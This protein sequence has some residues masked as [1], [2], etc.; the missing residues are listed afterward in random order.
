ME[1]RDGNWTLYDHDL[2]TGRT[3]WHYFDGER[4]HFRTDYPVDQILQDNKAARNDLAGQN[5]GGGQRIASIP[6]NIYFEQLDEAHAQGDEKYMSKWLNDIEH[7][8]FRTF[9][10]RV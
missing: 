2:H 9:E 7:S 10:G 1:I 3:V 5:W 8:G 4:D 6:L